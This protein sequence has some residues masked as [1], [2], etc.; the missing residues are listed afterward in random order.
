MYLHVSRLKSWHIMLWHISL[1]FLDE[2]LEKMSFFWR[3]SCC[4]T[5]PVGFAYIII[6]CGY[7]TSDQKELRTAT[8]CHVARHATMSIQSNPSSLSHKALL[9]H[10]TTVASLNPSYAGRVGAHRN[11]RRPVS[12]PSR[13][14]ITPP[15]LL[16]FSHLQLST[17]SSR[18]GTS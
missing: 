18:A 1:A 3:C 11:T 8:R 9:E 14:P 16:A 17:P 2:L 12:R 13:L 6:N 5:A 7:L 4:Y 10:D 15:P